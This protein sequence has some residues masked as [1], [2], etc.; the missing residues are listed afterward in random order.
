MEEVLK[1]VAGVVGSL[2]I[3][4]LGYFVSRLM[5]EHDTQKE[6]SEKQEQRMTVFEQKQLTGLGK[7]DTLETKI[8]ERNKEFFKIIGEQ[9]NKLG[10][11]NTT[12]ERIKTILELTKK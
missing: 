6:R 10:E 11:I 8:D 12:L 9:N 7:L 1:T 2:V 3:T 4:V 5:K